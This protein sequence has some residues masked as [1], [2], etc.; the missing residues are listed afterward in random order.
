M[1]YSQNIQTDRPD[2]TECPFIVTEKYF[3]LE[4]GFSFEQTKQDNNQIVAP[5]IL[6][7]YGVSKR[8]ELRLFASYEIEKTNFEKNAKISP[9]F[10]GFK[11]LL[12]NEN[13][14]IPTISF[15][16]HLAIPELNS[17]I[18]QNKFTSPQFRFTMQHTLSKKQSLSYN[19]GTE[20]DSEYEK[21]TFVYTLTSGYTLTAKTG[22]Y[23]EWYGF[24]SEID[25]SDYSCDGGFT[26]L[27]NPN[28]QL[29][30]STGF[31]LS[32]ISPNLYFALGYSLKFKAK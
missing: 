12:L 25:N 10:C 20:W 28:N 11:V 21:P 29:D 7:K 15:I 14:I 22:I 5:A 19:I 23:I 17:N 31:G 13:R 1:A 27:I 8:F 18:F 24:I 4:S 30:I 16:G 3:Q 26:Y 2:Q 6:A 32:E 9:V